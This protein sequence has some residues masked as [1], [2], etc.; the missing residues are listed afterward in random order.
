MQ[1][2]SVRCK[3]LERHFM[4]DL[5]DLSPFLRRFLGEALVDHRHDFVEQ[6]AGALL[7]AM[8]QGESESPDILAICGIGDLLHQ[9]R[10]CPP[11]LVVRGFSDLSSTY[12][13]PPCSSSLAQFPIPLPPFLCSS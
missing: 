6:L 4:T 8:A 2:L 10:R 13:V 12:Q 1:V 11:R 7:S 5:V 3:E 9:S